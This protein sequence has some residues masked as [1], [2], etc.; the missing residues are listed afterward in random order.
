MSTQNEGGEKTQDKRT[1]TTPEL[2][3]FGQI[4]EMTDS[5]A[6]GTA[7]DTTAMMFAAGG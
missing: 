3:V 2:Q 4:A 1:Y 7:A 5:I 6:F